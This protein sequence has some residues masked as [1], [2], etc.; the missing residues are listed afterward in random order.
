[1][2][3][4]GAA[5]QGHELRAIPVGITTSGGLGQRL[6]LGP[7]EAVGD[8]GIASNLLAKGRHGERPAG[9]LRR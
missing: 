3:V 9:R 4:G 1:M 5:H 8:P 7:V 2:G 6:H